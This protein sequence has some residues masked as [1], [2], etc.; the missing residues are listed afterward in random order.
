MNNLRT[1]SIFKVWISVFVGRH[2]WRHPAR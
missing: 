2:L 1:L